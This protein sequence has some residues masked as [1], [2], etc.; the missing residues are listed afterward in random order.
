MTLGQVLLWIRDIAQ[1]PSLGETLKAPG[2]IIFK[3]TKGLGSTPVT[4]SLWIIVQPI[5]CQHLMFA[6]LVR[7][8]PACKKPTLIMPVQGCN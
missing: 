5:R 1:T 3:S 6:E 8:L 4:G 7:L 2:Y